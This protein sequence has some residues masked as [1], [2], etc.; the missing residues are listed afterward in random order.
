[1]AAKLYITKDDTPLGPTEF[2]SD[3]SFF[4][5]ERKNANLEILLKNRDEVLVQ[6]FNGYFCQGSAEFER[7]DY[8]SVAVGSINQPGSLVLARRLL[9]S[10]KQV[11]DFG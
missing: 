11:F 3:C 1:M 10:E 8:H 4:V 7:F 2:D 6:G 5:Y 9:L